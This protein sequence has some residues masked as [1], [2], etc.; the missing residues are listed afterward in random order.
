MFLPLPMQQ[1]TESLISIS[2]FSWYVS[3]TD[4]RCWMDVRVFGSVGLS[5]PLPGSPEQKLLPDAP[6]VS[7]TVGVVPPMY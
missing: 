3:S 4:R 5:A 2:L 6:T 7:M 1:A